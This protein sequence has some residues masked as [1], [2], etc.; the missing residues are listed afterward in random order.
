MGFPIHK[1]LCPGVR[2]RVRAISPDGVTF[3]RR[4]AYVKIAAAVNTPPTIER[5]I[6]LAGG[7]TSGFD[8]LRIILAVSVLCWHTIGLTYG[9]EFADAVM[10]GW[11]G[12]L[13]RIILPMFFAL[14]GFLIAASLERNTL[15]TFLIF[16][17]LRIVPA[18]AVEIALS[19]LVLGPLMTTLPWRE[20]FSD[21][22][23]FA[24]A[25]NV[26][27]FIH[28][29]LPGLF[30]LNPFAAIVNGSLFTIPYELE[31]YL[32][33][34]LLALVG[35]VAR[36]R[37]LFGALVVGTLGLIIL[38]H[39]KAADTFR[40]DSALPPRSLVLCFLAGVLLYVTRA[41]VP[42]SKIVLLAAAALSALFLS[43]ASLYAFS[44]IPIAYVTVWLGLQNPPKL[45][46][47]FSGDYSYGVYLYAFPNS[48][49]LDRADAAAASILEN[50]RAVA[51]FGFLLCRL[52]LVGN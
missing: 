4:Q 52:F 16:R 17:G 44:P 23:F 10:A 20:Y 32:A 40:I 31:C 48:A 5:R 33:L 28:Y 9:A 37:L 25:L 3:D 1:A 50:H 19:A 2:Y 24:Y 30:D 51:D 45:P 11:A 7:P 27:G 22:R 49:G 47:I 41:L 8:Y 12:P 6:K 14:S 21:D 43:R 13:V 15:P 34:V 35:I 38:A 36:P 29:Q 18:L 42:Y 26:I 46:V 39:F